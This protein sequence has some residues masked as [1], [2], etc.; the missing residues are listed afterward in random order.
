MFESQSNKLDDANV[1]SNNGLECRDVYSQSN[2]WM[3]WPVKE[4][5]ASRDWAAFYEYSEISRRKQSIVVIAEQM[6]DADRMATS[7]SDRFF[8]NAVADGTDEEREHSL[9]IYGLCGR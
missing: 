8:E 4:S 9:C 2:G 3:H 7:Q 6:S 1:V 5:V